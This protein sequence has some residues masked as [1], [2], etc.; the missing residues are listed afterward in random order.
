MDAMIDLVLDGWAPPSVEQVVDRAG[1]SQASLFRYFGT[2]AELRHEAIGRYVERFDDLMAIPGIGD[3]SLTGRIDRFVT[4]RDA[5]YARTAPMARLTRRQAAE[6]ADF[7][8]TIDRVR[9]TFVDQI[10]QHFA[11]ELGGDEHRAAVIAALTSFEAWEQLASLGTDGRRAA[12]RSAIAALLGRPP[13][14]PPTD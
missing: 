12:Q 5:F 2:L 6:V 8:E 9:A 3:G 10:A 11:P 13:D 7:A 14:A 4:A 1:V